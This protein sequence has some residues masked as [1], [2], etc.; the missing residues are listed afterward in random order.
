MP[1]L[2]TRT[3]QALAPVLVRAAKSTI[4][5]GREAHAAVQE[6]AA[7]TGAPELQQSLSLLQFGLVGL[8]NIPQVG[9]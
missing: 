3:L 2:R 1:Q 6:A 7:A 4:Q 9:C 5:A 8:G